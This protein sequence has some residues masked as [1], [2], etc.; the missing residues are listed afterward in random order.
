MG[1]DHALEIV[2]I[3]TIK[4]KMFDGTILTIEE[5]RHVKCLK[6]NLLSPGQIDSHRCKTHVENEIIKIAKSPLVLMKVEKFG[7]NLFILKGE[8]L[9]EADACVASKGEESMMMWHLKLGHM[10]EQGLKILSKR[11]LLLG[12]KSVSLPFC[13]HCVTNKQYRLKFSRSIT[14]SKCILDLIHSDVWESPDISIGGAKYM[15]TFINDNSMICWVYPIKKKS[16]IFLVFKE[17]KA[18]VELESGKMIKCLRT[19][20]DGEYTDDKF[21]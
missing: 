13:K 14:R 2:G 8:T 15:V 3:G 16:D 21:R 5:I 12:L 1:D 6:N 17:Y 18:R 20:N 11:K 7:A 4:I 9:Q 19:D 10:S